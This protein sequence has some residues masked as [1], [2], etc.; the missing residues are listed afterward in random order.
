MKKVL[1]V[2]EDKDAPQFRYRVK[3]PMEGLKDSNNWQVECV[4]KSEVGD[5]ELD[6][7]SLVVI[8]RQTAKDNSIL[9]LIEKAK[10]TGVKVLFDIDDLV[11]DYNDLG[12]VYSTVREKSLLYWA[13]YFWGIR[14]IAKR[15]DGFL[16]TNEYLG[17]RLNR[18]FKRPY[19][20]IKNSLNK[21]QVDNSERII[22]KKK[23]KRGFS[24]GYFSGSPTHTNDFRLIEPELIR[25][26]ETHDNAML[27][28][29]GDMSYSDEMRK[30]I[31]G[32][33]VKTT[34]KVGYLELLGLISEVDVNLAPLVVNDF[35]NC[36]SDLKFFE[37][38]VVETITI[39]SPTYAFKEAINDGENGFLAEPH[40][41]FDKIEY[42][43]NNSEKKEKIAKSA[44]KYVLKNYYGKDYMK[45]VE[46]AYDFFAK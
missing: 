46:E 35:T 5:L 24:V 15:V 11:F 29:V 10:R 37:A 44:R 1:Y 25:F 17:K 19:K 20:V 23:S 21:E 12:L 7:Y 13:G 30:L 43:Y 33:R 28:V 45:E 2:V 34:G 31:D 18:S 22:K 38:A 16:C 39:A 32:G 9:R 42:L 26:L 3:S 4:L 27:K 40:G 41:W 36:K 8:V 6:A 14:R